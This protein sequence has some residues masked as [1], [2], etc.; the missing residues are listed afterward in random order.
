MESVEL[1]TKSGDVIVVADKL[2]AKIVVEDK[3]VPSLLNDD[4][5]VPPLIMGTVSEEVNSAKADGVV[6]S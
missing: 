1:K 3:D 4:T 2:A 6:S 5:P